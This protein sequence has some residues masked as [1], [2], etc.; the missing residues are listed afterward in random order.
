MHQIGIREDF[1]RDGVMLNFLVDESL[2]SHLAR[3]FP[4]SIINVGYP[5]ICLKE[6]ERCRKIVETLEQEQVET[7]VV[8]H[9]LPSHLEVMA[10]IINSY[11]NSSG[12]FW[13]PISDY[14]ISQTLRKEPK[15]LL[16]YTEEMIRYWKG[17]SDKPIDVALA[18]CTAKELGLRERL[19]FFYESLKE[20]GARSIIIC[21]T[22]GIATPR[23]LTDLLVG[24]RD[25]PELEFHPHN[26]NHLALENIEVA[27]NLGVKRIGTSIYGFGERGT[28]VDPR[29]LVAKYKIPYNPREFEYFDIKYHQLINSLNEPGKLFTHDTIITGTQYRLRGRNPAFVIKFGVTSDKFILAKLLGVGVSEIS[30]NVLATL[31]D[32]LYL[33]RKRIFTQPELKERYEKLK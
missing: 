1:R 21:D 5:A 23:R 9:A 13:I 18:D 20:S 29:D 8:G 10:K 12:N 6:Q 24:F 3:T 25:H 16:K 19:S 15:N 31:K 22:R 7:A 14:F 4:N 33:E 2:M 26:D 11:K 28:M 30:D 17:I 27:I 32:Q